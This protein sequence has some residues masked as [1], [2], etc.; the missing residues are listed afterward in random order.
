MRV[1][2][3]PASCGAVTEVTRGLSSCVSRRLVDHGILATGGI[4]SCAV[5]H[6]NMTARIFG[7]KL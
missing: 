6:Y 1:Q 2:Q 5:S 7:A 3:A 4:I